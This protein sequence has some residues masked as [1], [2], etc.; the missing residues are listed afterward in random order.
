MN[1][2]KL[3]ENKKIRSVWNEADNMWYFVVADV[4]S[5]LTDSK[6][7]KQYIKRMRLRD[8]ELSK[9][10]VQIVPTLWVETSGGKQKM[11]CANAKGL[12]RM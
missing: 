8:T 7:P 5:I 3:F 11:S 4:I 2:I 9:G 10:W 12:L 1:N 6:D